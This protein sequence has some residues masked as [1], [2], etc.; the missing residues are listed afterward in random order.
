VNKSRAKGTAW[1]AAIVKY[2]ID[3]GWP[4]AET[5]DL[6]GNKDRGDIAGLIGVMIEA[7]NEK[8]ITLAQYANEVETQTA[9]DNASIGAAWIKRPRHTDPGKG[10]V[11]IDGATFTQLL[12]DAGYQ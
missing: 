2:L 6:H 11:L 5:R 7:K 8:T 3:Q 9:N 1:A 4:H 10:Y 12:K